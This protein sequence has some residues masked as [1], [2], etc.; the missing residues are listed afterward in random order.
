MITGPI[1]IFDVG[2]AAPHVQSGVNLTA[3]SFIS[4]STTGPLPETA[5]VIASELRE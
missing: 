5:A 4:N 2:F 3:A 1:Q